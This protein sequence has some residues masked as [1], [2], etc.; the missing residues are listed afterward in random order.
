METWAERLHERMVAAGKKPAELARACGIQP[1][2]VSGWFGQGKP[3]KMISGDNLIAAAA[4]LEV[5][6]EF[7]M[8]GRSGP[9]R[10]SHTVG[11]DI[12]KLAAVLAVVEGAIRDS[13]KSV[14]ASFKARMI[15]R[16]YE[17]KHELTAET[18]DA[19]Q[20]AIAGILETMG[21]E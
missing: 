21:T 4:F 18:A 8:T 10:E 20:A 6:P 1:G 11:L 12:E 5:S 9:R 2:S 14:P 16:V 19:V 13:G 3:T 15:K 17:G 7:I